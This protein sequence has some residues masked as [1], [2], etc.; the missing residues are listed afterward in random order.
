MYLLLWTR[1]C[2]QWSH[3]D[4][5]VSFE[6]TFYLVTLWP[7]DINDHANK[8]IYILASLARMYSLASALQ[9]HKD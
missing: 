2:I 9:S 4:S 8:I 3:C 7:K 1:K 6:I 5:L